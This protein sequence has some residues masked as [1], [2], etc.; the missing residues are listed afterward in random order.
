MNWNQKAIV[1]WRM[2]HIM[3]SLPNW[4]QFSA[5][6]SEAPDWLINF[7]QQQ[8][9]ALRQQ[10]LPTQKNER[11]KYA[12]FSQLNTSSFSKVMRSSV[13]KTKTLQTV[14]DS[15]RIQ[16]P[17]SIFLVFENGYFIPS[18]SAL[19]RLPP[20]V[21][22]CSLPEA[23]K[24]HA[25]L[26]ETFFK[27]ELETERYPFA[28]LN[29]ANFQDGLFFYLADHQTLTAPIHLL[30]IASHSQAFIAHPKHLL[31]L[32]KNSK[33]TLI[34]D[35]ISLDAQSYM[36][37][38][39]TNILVQEAAQLEHYKIQSE[40]TQ[41]IHLAASFIEQEQNSKVTCLHFSSGG[42]FAREEVIVSLQGQGAECS[43]SGF[44]RLE[45]DKQYID[46]HIDILHAAP[47]TQSRML[48]KGIVDKKSRAVFNGRLHVEKGA[49]KIIAHQENHN[50]L[51]STTA[52]VNS[53]P[54]LE[55]YSDDVKCKH[56][57]TTGQINQETLFYLCSRGIP[58][59]T[60]QRILLKGFADDVLQRIKQ[61]DIKIRLQ[62][63]V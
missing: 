29:A 42:A 61:P 15:F 43:T 45:Q 1:G 34:E 30:F 28:S 44:Y 36:M 38:T 47:H 20:H 11:W 50:L 25:S 55:I 53:K 21:I 10:G 26:V 54:E 6:E 58:R 41:A 4:L 60:A 18:L 5:F 37:N 24:T 12:D 16:H 39:V 27:K 9:K 8:E 57:A 7:R 17:D 59:D 51:L 13:E 19:D 2:N 62:E 31:V 49:Q 63:L 52:E 35:Y 14:I 46:Y 32:G 56:G 3:I 22:A 33:L 48:Y 23:C 40:N